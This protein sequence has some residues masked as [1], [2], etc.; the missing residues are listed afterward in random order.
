MI[1]IFSF[2]RD[3]LYKRPQKSYQCVSLKFHG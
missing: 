1:E 2:S 3:S